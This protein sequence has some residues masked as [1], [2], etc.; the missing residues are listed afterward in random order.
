MASIGVVYGL[1]Q[2]NSVISNYDP[3]NMGF[4]P[5][6]LSMGMTVSFLTAG[7]IV[8]QVVVDFVM[9]ILKFY[10]KKTVKTVK[11]S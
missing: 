6:L 2:Y 7:G 4:V 9:R 3:T 5:A 8:I 10:S 11:N 1:Y